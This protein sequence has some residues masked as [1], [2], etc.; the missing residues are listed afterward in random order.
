MKNVLRKE[1]LLEDSF[2]LGVCNEYCFMDNDR[3]Y[4]T[5]EGNTVYFNGKEYC[6]VN[7]ELRSYIAEKC[8]EDLPL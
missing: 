7:E 2:Y 3:N 6:K 1:N 4:Y 5:L 8:L